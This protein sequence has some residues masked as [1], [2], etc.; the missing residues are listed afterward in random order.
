M[1]VGVYG[2]LRMPDI[3]TKLHAASKAA[4]LGV[5][6]FVVA[7]LFTGDPAIISRVLLIGAILILTTPVAS[8]VIG[9]AGYLEHLPMISRDAVDESGRHLADADALPATL[10]LPQTDASDTATQAISRNQP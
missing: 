6:S 10:T 3:Y 9:R 4:F 7:S 2:M 5:N 8:H 1:T